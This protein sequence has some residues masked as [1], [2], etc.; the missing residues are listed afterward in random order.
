MNAATLTPARLD[1]RRRV[2]AIRDALAVADDLLAAAYA[3][4]DWEALG[5]ADWLAY[6]AAELPELRHITMRAPA[7]RQRVS[8]L[9][10]AGASMREMSAATG[11]S[12]GTVHADVAQLQRRSA[13]APAATTRTDR[14]VALLMAAGPAGLT[15]HQVARRERCHHGAASAALSR[16]AAAGRAH[17]LTAPRGV[18]SPYVLTES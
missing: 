14:V 6:C 7:R 15:V 9:L 18:T 2:A 3:A 11:A 5:H 16:L 8:A 10:D 12:L 4:R 13:P 17:R 1:A